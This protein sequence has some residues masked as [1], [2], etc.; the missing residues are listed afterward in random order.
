MNGPHAETT[1]I[2]QWP[3]VYRAFAAALII[4]VVVVASP[5]ALALLPHTPAICPLRTLTGVPCPGC[6]ATR[7]FFTLGSGHLMTSLR[8]NPLGPFLWL[9]FA[10]FVA[11][12]TSLLPRR[13]FDRA[14]TPVFI[15]GVT[16]AV[17]AWLVTLCRRFLG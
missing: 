15:A 7:S 1:V 2:G 13:L 12:K 3:A 11:L 16:A 4:V 8:L 5:W 10:A 9:A 17:L 6:G 14:K